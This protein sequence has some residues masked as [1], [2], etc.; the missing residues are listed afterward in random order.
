MNLSKNN[1]NKVAIITGGSSGIGKATAIHMA[2][3]GYLVV[4]VARNKDRL[5]EV[6]EQIVTQ[7]GNAVYYTIDITNKE[8]VKSCIESVIEKYHRIDFL[9]NNAGVGL[10]GTSDIS[11][12]AIEQVLQINLKSAIFIAKYV[13][14]HMKEQKFGYII[15]LSSLSGKVSSSNLGIYNASKF[16]ISGF[17]EALAK[18]MAA[19]GVKVTAICPGMVATDMTKNFNFKSEWMIDVNDICQTVEYLLNLGPNALLLEVVINCVPFVLK[20]VEAEAKIFS[21]Q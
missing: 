21:E 10:V 5:I 1:S 3:L 13:A 9:F 12:E 2:K 14:I 6:Q 8:E 20:M 16:G 7:N 4:L 15:N 11:D 18:E 17:S 19:F